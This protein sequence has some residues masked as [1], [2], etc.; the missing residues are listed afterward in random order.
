MAGSIRLV[1]EP[2]TWELRVYLGRDSEGSGATSPPSVPGQSPGGGARA[3]P[4]GDGAGDEAGLDSRPVARVGTDN[5]GQR[6]HHGVEGQRLVRSLAR[7]PP[8]ITRRCGHFISRSRSVAVGSHR[9]TPFD[10]E[11]YL[12]KLKD[13]GLSQERVRRIRAILHRACRLAR[14]WSGNTPRQSDYGHRT[15]RCL[16]SPRAPMKSARRR[17]MRSERSWGSARTGDP[18]IAAFVRLVTAT[19]LRRGEACAL[20]WSDVDIDRKQICID[21]SVVIGRAGI[22]V[23]APKTRASIRT[24]AVDRGTLDDLSSLRARQDEM[25][26]GMRGDPGSRRLRLFARGRRPPGTPARLAQSVVCPPSGQCRRGI[27]HPPSF[28]PSFRG[29]RTRFGDLGASEAVPAGLVDGPDGPALHRQRQ[30][31]GSAGSR[32]HGRADRRKKEPQ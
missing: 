22:Q 12:R 4:T 18:R 24:I 17:S 8:P 28:P 2:D 23:K 3:G 5:D 21:K 16:A 26:T 11:Q 19:G 30:R 1:G 27:R 31:R 6:R 13:S 20:R 15:A 25:R 14:K 10:V 9:C 32:P 7:P 29:H